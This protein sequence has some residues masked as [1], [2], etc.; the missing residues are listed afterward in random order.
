MKRAT[1]AALLSGLVFPGIGHLYLKVRARG[2]ALLVTALVALSVIIRTAYQQAQLVV[3]EVLSGQ[4]AM[5]SDAIAQ[6]VAD[7][8]STADSLVYNVAVIVLVAC[9]L[10]AIFDAYRLGARD[11]ESIT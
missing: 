3:D 5:D 7:S 1:K 9:W 4:V 2:Y 11:E 6:A 8:A 10:G